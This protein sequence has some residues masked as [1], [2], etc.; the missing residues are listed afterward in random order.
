MSEHKEHKHAEL[1]EQMARDAR[2]TDKPHH[3]YES[4]NDGEWVG[5]KND[6]SL[7]CFRESSEYRR[8]P[9]WEI[10]G[11]AV[12]DSVILTSGKKAVVKSLHETGKFE[13]YVA[14]LVGIG[15]ELSTDFKKYTPQHETNINGFEVPQPLKSLKEG[16]PF[17]YVSFGG[18]IIFSV[19]SES[20]VK[21]RYVLGMGFCH[22]TKEAAEIHSQALDSFKI[23]GGE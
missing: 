7:P 4:K 23:K 1:I 11:L 21:H 10:D 16:E 20:C 8:I 6:D 5:F 3:W 15:Q 17:F 13:I 18:R 12:G 22:S 19:F 14:V 2:K 9:Q